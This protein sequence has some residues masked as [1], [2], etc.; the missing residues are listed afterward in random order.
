MSW[1]G[2]EIKFLPV[3]NPMNRDRPIQLVESMLSQQLS[4]LLT[5]LWVS[6][7]PHFALLNYL[8]LWAFDGFPHVYC[9]I[10][11]FCHCFVFPVEKKKRLVRRK[12][13]KNRRLETFFICVK[14]FFQSTYPSVR[15]ARVK[16]FSDQ[17]KWNPRFYRSTMLSDDVIFHF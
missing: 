10:W 15:W 1:R 12:K 13:K 16:D 3:Y 11:L 4:R 2:D 8:Q 5:L 17:C 14:R 9:Q 7:Y 6:L